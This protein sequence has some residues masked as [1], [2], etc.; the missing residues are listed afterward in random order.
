MNEITTLLIHLHPLLDTRTFR[1]LKRISEALPVMIGRVTQL[2]ISR[3]IEKGGSYRTVHRFFQ[4]S[5]P[6]DRLNWQLVKMSLPKNLGVILVGGD[7]NN[8]DQIR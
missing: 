7:C 6:W 1:Q 2:S 5:I 4:K 8:S 3:W